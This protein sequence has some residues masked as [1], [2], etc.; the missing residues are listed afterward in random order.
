[1]PVWWCCTGP[2]EAQGVLEVA[3]RDI[4]GGTR[5]AFDGEGPGAWE[6]AALGKGMGAWQEEGLGGC[7]GA[8]RGAALL[9][10]RCRKGVLGGLERLTAFH[11]VCS[12]PLSLAVHPDGVR[13]ASG[14][15]AGVDKDG[16]VR[17]KSNPGGQGE[18]PAQL[19][20]VPLTP[21]PTPAS[22][23]CGSCLGFRDADEA[24]GDWTGGLRAGCGGPG[25]FSCGKLAPKP[26]DPHLP[27]LRTPF[28]HFLRKL[29]K[30]WPS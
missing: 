3:A 30:F 11:R 21:S 19:P 28:L 17:P 12:P 20:F 13:V 16:K 26:L 15:T 29:Q 2:G 8:E 6:W 18:I 25:L 5:T 27:C 4:T 9:L 24:A 14:Q 10:C 1:M 7:G 23:A 22:A